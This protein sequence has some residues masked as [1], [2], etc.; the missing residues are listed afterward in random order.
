MSAFEVLG[1]SVVLDVH[2]VGSSLSRSDGLGS[3]VEVEEL[4]LETVS[5]L[6]LN[7]VSNSL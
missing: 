1:R 6:K 2:G 4:S 5:G 3:V 7:V